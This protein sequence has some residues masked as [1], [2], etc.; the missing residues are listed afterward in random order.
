LLAGDATGQAAR[1]LAQKFEPARF[2]APESLDFQDDLIFGVRF[3]AQDAA[4]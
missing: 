4:R 2:R 3:H 1:I